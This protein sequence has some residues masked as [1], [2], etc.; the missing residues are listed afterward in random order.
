MKMHPD[1]AHAIV[2]AALKKAPDGTKRRLITNV[3]ERREQAED[4]IAA[5]IVVAL[6]QR[7]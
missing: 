6:A 3:P 2:L 4:V 7:Q 5:S 1:L